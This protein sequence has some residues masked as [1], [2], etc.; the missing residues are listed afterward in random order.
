MYFGS[1]L[2]KE[3]IISDD[4]LGQA[5][6]LQKE[7]MPSLYKT[8]QN[9]NLASEEDLKKVLNSINEKKQD[10][11]NVI[12]NEKII[13][14]ET[15]KKARQLQAHATKGIGECLADLGILEVK[16]VEEHLNNYLVIRKDSGE[17]IQDN[18]DSVVEEVPQETAP[19]KSS[20]SEP[21]LSEAALE[22]LKELNIST[23]ELSVG[24]EVSDVQ[25]E[26]SRPDDGET[27]LSEAALES[28]KELNIST[29]ELSVGGEVSDVQEE[30]SNSDDVETEL[31]EAA[32][33]SLRELGAISEEEISNLTS[34]HCSETTTEPQVEAVSSTN[35]VDSNEFIIIDK[36]AENFV[37]EYLNTFSEKMFN[38][39]NKIAKFIKE[40]AD[41]NGDIANFFNSLYRDIHVVKVVAALVESKLSEKLLER[42]ENIIEG[43]F[44]KSNDQLKEWV[45]V[46]LSLMRTSIEICW[47]IRSCIDEN[48]SEKSLWSDDEWKDK[49]LDIYKRVKSLEE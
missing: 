32:L 39:L 29:E 46:N 7:S 40:T 37:D 47:E 1:Y 41:N 38:K 45:E 16:I 27:E 6:A 44:T 14:I 49:F 28:L 12:K 34:E 8:L 25:E 5:L 9:N 26:A 11:I 15:L 33:E 43:I 23:E 24:I 17:D 42:W 48:M 31:S 21:E 13:D 10:L 22:S 18:L 35:N 20:S 4:Q 3:K 2:V 36:M 30:A 19:E